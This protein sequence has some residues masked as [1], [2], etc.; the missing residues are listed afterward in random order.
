MRERPVVVHKM[1]TTSPR[2]HHVSTMYSR[3]HA[4]G[5]DRQHAVV[6]T[7]HLRRIV[8]PIDQIRDRAPRRTAKSNRSV[9]ANGAV[10]T[11]GSRD[12]VRRHWPADRA[13]EVL[14]RFCAAFFRAGTKSS[15]GSY[16]ARRRAKCGDSNRESPA[17]SVSRAP[18]VRA[19]RNALETESVGS[20]PA[21]RSPSASSST[22]VCATVMR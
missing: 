16:P 3:A 18:S 15:P 17:R 12:T 22:N 10:G 9:P 8:Q 14:A 19:T 21:I 13:A 6:G 20:M 1:P 4:S 7:L 5:S 11:A 2:V